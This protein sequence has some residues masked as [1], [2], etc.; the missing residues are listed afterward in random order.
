MWKTFTHSNEPYMLKYCKNDK[1]ITLF[2]T[3]LKQLW[4]KTVDFPTISAN[5]QVWICV[6]TILYT[7]LITFRN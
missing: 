1:D 2:L 3:N 7:Y 5:F 6:N 4:S